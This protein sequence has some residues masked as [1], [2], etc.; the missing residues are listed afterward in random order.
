MLNF[1]MPSALTE[2][3]AL[4]STRSWGASLRTGRKRALE[5]R[6]ILVPFRSSRQATGAPLARNL[7]EQR[8]AE[9]CREPRSVTVHNAGQSSAA[10]LSVESALSHYISHVP[11]DGGKDGM[12]TPQRGRRE[13]DK[14]AANGNPAWSSLQVAGWSAIR[15][16]ASTAPDQICDIRLG[17]DVT[18]AYL[19]GKDAE[20]EEAQEYAN[21]SSLALY[22]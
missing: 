12:R 7:F 10:C 11:T 15:K 19:K 5:W 2:A 22:A 8:S 18:L 1:A 21:S 17:Q 14:R 3:F 16:S 20:S 9:I 6:R 13:F 4:L